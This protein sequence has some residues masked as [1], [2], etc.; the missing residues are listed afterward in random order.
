[1]KELYRRN[2]QLEMQMDRQIIP[3]GPDDMSMMMPDDDFYAN[4]REM[5]ICPDCK[6]KKYLFVDIPHEHQFMNCKCL[7]WSVQETDFEGQWN[8]FK[9]Q[10]QY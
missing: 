5:R 2:E 6:K 4:E 10:M 3:I 7:K 1:M 9:S 8:I